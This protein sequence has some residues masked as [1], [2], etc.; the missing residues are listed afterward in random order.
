VASLLTRTG[1]LRFIDVQ[2]FRQLFLSEPVPDGFE[3]AAALA[4]RA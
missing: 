1:E 4:Q 2:F 3:V